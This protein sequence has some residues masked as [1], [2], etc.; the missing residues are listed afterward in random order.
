MDLPCFVSVGFQQFAGY[1]FLMLFIYNFVYFFLAVFSLRDMGQILLSSL[2]ST[3]V[4]W[5]LSLIYQILFTNNKN[6]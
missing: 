3:A 5:V 1:L 4:V 2:L 6:T